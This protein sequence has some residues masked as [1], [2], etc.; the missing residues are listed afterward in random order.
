MYIMRVWVGGKGDFQL[1]AAM[2][3]EVVIRG[4]GRNCLHLGL[5]TK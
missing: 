4:R 2:P 3:H 1:R 5:T